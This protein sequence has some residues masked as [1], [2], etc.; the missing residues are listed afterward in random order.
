[1]LRR[2][3]RLGGRSS[4]F[5]GDP[6]SAYGH[7]ASAAARAAIQSLVTLQ[8]ELGGN[9]LVGR[10]LYPLLIEAGFARVRVS[11]RIVYVDSSRPDLGEGFTRNTFTAMVEGAREA[12]IATGIIEPGNFDAGIRD[13]NRSS[14]ADGVFCYTF[15]KGVATKE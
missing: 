15:F 8:R 9:A 5:E 12:A 6:G 2:R 4:V 1:M 11:P 3:P 7:P 14:E 10:Q 13:L